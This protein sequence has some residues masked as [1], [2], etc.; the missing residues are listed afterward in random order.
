LCQEPRNNH[1][2]E[3]T[4]Y[5]VMQ[6]VRRLGLSCT[7]VFFVNSSG[8]TNLYSCPPQHHCVVLLYLLVPLCWPEYRW[9]MGACLTIEVNTWFL[10]LRRIVYKRESKIPA[11]CIQ[12]VDKLFYITWL[13]IRCLIF[14]AI[15]VKLVN[16]AATVVEV[17]GHFW[18]LCFVFVPLHC[19]LC[20]L[21]LKWT[22]DLFK[23]ILCKYMTGSATKTSIVLTGL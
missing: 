21:N 13:V 17:T 23:P 16:L 18:H 4:K 10:I 11:F 5:A 9:L 19:S 1:Q 22:Y 6:F 3:F 8:L 12:L 7:Y 15:L 2:G 20:I 14:P